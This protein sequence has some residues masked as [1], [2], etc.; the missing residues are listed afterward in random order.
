MRSPAPPSS[1]ST[2]SLPAS[3]AARSLWPML[4]ALTAAFG[5]SQA[6]RTVATIIAAPLEADF[7]IGAQA[8]GVFAG[9]YHF[10]FGV[11]QMFVG[12]GIDLHGVRR[13]V[14][15][16]FP[17]A[18]A[19]S[20]LTALAHS[21][22][23]LVLGQALIGLGCAPTFLAST[24]FIARHLPPAR[25][26]VVSG[27]VLS[28]GGIGMLLTGT[29][30]AWLIEASSWRVGFWVLCAFAAL[31]WLAILA[32]V[33]EPAPLHAAEAVPQ[34]ESLREAFA[35]FG[36]LLLLRHT[37][38]I[39]LLSAVGYASFISLRGL[40]LGPMLMQRHGFS[41]VQSGNVALVMSLVSLVSPP[42][43][44]RLDPGPARRRAWIIGYTLVAAALFAAP[45]LLHLAWL[46]VASPLAIGLLSGYMVLQYADVR[47][48]YPAQL[49]GRALALFT[50]AMFLGVAF[51]QWFTGLIASVAIAHAVEPYAAVLGA[52]AALLVLGALAFMLLPAPTAQR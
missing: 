39:L 46:D 31:A 11:M 5:M 48:A 26:A 13:T 50:M 45:A 27:Q 16:A 9:A 41:L 34:R 6:F 44:G 25:F 19:G 1:S 3:T 18:I 24:V 21:F 15:A 52:I 33:H 51:M 43:F 14:L 23:L 20:V 32:L 40:W 17:L 38:G 47:A 4:L 30:L 22:P 8:L 28:I 37:L 42:L 29:P 35:K 2:P 12:I 49:T 36:A 7:H 10:S